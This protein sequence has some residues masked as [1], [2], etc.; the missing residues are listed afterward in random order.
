MPRLEE[1]Q[2]RVLIREKGERQRRGLSE[3]EARSRR[4]G[5]EEL[6]R[7][8]KERKRPGERFLPYGQ[9]DPH[10]G[11]PVRDFGMEWLMAGDNEDE[12]KKVIDKYVKKLIHGR[13]GYSSRKAAFSRLM[14]EAARVE[15]RRFE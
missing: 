9:P 13:Y 10:T 7:E 15:K 4:E 6:S 12:Q 11:S 8:L 5:T 14:Q 1:I 2:Q 3:E